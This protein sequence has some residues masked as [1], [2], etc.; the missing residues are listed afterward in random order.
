MAAS[1]PTGPAGDKQFRRDAAHALGTPL[2]SLLLQ[3][4]L[5]EHYLHKH[6]VVKASQAAASL[7]T[8]CEAFGHILRS[9]FS[10][11]ADMSE[12]GDDR[13]DPR[14]CLSDALAELG[15][16][17]VAIEY[18]GESPLVGLP[19][20]VL[21]AL[22]RRLAV[23]ATGL[24]A[25]DATLSSSSENSSLRLSLNSHRGKKPRMQHNPFE[26]SAALNLWTL[27]EMAERHHGQLV[28]NDEPR[29]LISLLLPLAEVR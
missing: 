2:G 9:I 10:A 18:R 8:D 23:E 17:T 5:I 15:D 24:D 13:G 4:E 11:M 12:A 16:E 20:S 25:Q 28:L 14:A 22:M 7:V 27:R 21:T 26:G 1:C 19:A 29:G 6:E 3:A